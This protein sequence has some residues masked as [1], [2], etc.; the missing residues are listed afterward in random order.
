MLED[1]LNNLVLLGAIGG[2][3]EHLKGLPRQMLKLGLISSLL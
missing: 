1:A 3:S 2:R